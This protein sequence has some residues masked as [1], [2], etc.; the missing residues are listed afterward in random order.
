MRKA[1]VKMKLG[2]AVTCTITGA[3]LATSLFSTFKYKELADA[4]QS[5]MQQV[6][7]MVLNNLRSGYVAATDIKMGEVITES[8]LSYSTKMISSVDQ[9]CFMDASDLGKIATMSI[10]A[11][12]PVYKTMLS[13]E[14]ASGLR[15]RECTFIWLNSNLRDYD[16]VDV[17]ILF[18]NGEDYIVAAKKSIYNARIAVNDVFLRLTEEEIQMLDAAVVDANM[19]NA[20]IY[21]T[22]YVNPEVQEASKVTYSPGSDVMRVI[23]MDSNIVEKSAIALSVDARSAMDKRLQLF[24]EAYPDFRLNEDVG[25]NSNYDATY[26]SDGGDTVQ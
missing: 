3:L 12:T 5:S 6:E 18:P 1:K 25:S 24:E 26:Y 9:G 20:K 16:F 13:D 7:N 22:K 11:G 4:S 14:E 8:M 21:V 15:E 10:G 19:H 2:L 17:R 23:A